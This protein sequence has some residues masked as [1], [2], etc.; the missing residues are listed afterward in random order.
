M[1]QERGITSVCFACG[2]CGVMVG[3]LSE[4]DSRS[5]SIWM[6]FPLSV[7]ALLLGSWTMAVG[8]VQVLGQNLK[9]GEE[10][11]VGLEGGRV[12]CAMFQIGG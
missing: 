12:F 1:N 6:F 4:S 11:F 8:R 10:D 7:L 3:L 5:Y 9:G 2:S